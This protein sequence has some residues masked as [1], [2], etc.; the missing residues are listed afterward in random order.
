MN[1]TPS[2]LQLSKVFYEVKA[3]MPFTAFE[4]LI[5]VHAEKIHNYRD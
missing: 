5:C 3:K 4:T 1:S 2:D